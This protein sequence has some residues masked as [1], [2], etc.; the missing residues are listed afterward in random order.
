MAYEFKDIDC[1]TFVQVQNIADMK[2][3]DAADGLRH[4]LEFHGQDGTVYV[5]TTPYMVTRNVCGFLQREAGI[6]EARRK[7]YRWRR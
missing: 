1:S 5:G 7:G 6:A 4:E 2:P 3:A